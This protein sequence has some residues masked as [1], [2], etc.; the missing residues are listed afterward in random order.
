[1]PI[2]TAAGAGLTRAANGSL[3]LKLGLAGQRD[4]A[5]LSSGAVGAG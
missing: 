4:C 1:M 5:I 3:D 2:W